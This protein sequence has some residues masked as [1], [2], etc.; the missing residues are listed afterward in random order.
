MDTE[1]EKI[2]RRAEF[3][4]RKNKLKIAKEK[5]NPE[6]FPPEEFPVSV[7]MAGSPGAG[8][9]ES[10]RKLIEKLTKDGRSVL[11][12]DIDEFRPIFEGYKGDNSYLFTSAASI[13]ADK[14]HDLALKNKQN[15][16]FDGTLSN[17]GRARE[18]IRRS[19]GKNRFIQIVYVYQDPKQAWE[20]VKGRETKEGRKI[21]RET[22]IEQY[23]IARENTNTLKREFGKDIEIFLIVKNI[24]GTD[25][26]SHG[27]IEIIDTYIPEKYTRDDLRKIIL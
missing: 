25:S 24:D 3:F 18:N 6:I 15:F 7:F 9:T 26:S 13:I 4:A 17:L 27:N 10:S 19:L 11:R 16:I 5:T 23:F 2:K 14:I 12:I 8:K 22:F 20:F 21:P 1:D